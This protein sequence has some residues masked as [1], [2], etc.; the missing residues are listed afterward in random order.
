MRTR[1]Q[2]L[3]ALAPLAAAALGAAAPSASRG[4]TAAASAPA[5]ASGPASAPP[6]SSP[7]PLT[8]ARPTFAVEIRT[9]P[10]WDAS[11]PPQAQALFREHSVHLRR[12]RD[13]GHILVGA[14][15]ADKGLLLV[16]AADVAAARALFE[17]DP[18]MKAG[19]FAFELHALAVFYGGCVH[20]PPRRG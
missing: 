8:D 19:T 6:T 3:A 13:E 10:A 9:G 11:K 14:R 18:S 12:L 17:A 20:P 7:G 5:G 2:A 15:Y 1:R 4:Q 16:T